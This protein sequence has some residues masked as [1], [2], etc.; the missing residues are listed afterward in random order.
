MTDLSKLD[1]LTGLNEEQYQ[2]VKQQG[3]ELRNIFSIVNQN[4]YQQP[5]IYCIKLD[6]QIV[7]V[8]RSKNMQA[9]IWQHIKSIND[10]SNENKYRVLHEAR[11]QGQTIQFDVLEY[12]AESRLDERERY[13]IA[14]YNPKLNYMNPNGVNR[15]AKTITYIELNEEMGE[16]RRYQSF[17]EWWDHGDPDELL[18]RSV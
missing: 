12:T 15:E 14:K 10:G 16:I 11:A 6:D 7:Y 3:R 18:T 8:G 9:R 17:L 13:Y 1:Q 4:K 5:G 2:G